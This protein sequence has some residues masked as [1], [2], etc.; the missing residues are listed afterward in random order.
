MNAKALRG[1]QNGQSLVLAEGNGLSFLLR[2]ESAALT[3]HGVHYRLSRRLSDLSIESGQPQPADPLEMERR[4]TR[5]GL[6][7][8]EAAIC[9]EFDL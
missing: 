2:R 4:V 7:E 9:L 1:F 6:E 8:F 3:S 5:L